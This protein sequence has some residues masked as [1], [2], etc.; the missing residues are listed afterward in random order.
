MVK[1]IGQLG[2]ETVAL[3]DECGEDNTPMIHKL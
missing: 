2:N 1:T 3:E